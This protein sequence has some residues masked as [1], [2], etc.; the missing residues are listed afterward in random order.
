EDP[1]EMG[2][3]ESLLTSLKTEADALVRHRSL[4]ANEIR[5]E[6]LEETAI[7]QMQTDGIL[8]TIRRRVV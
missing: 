1:N 2:S 5:P 4:S 8:S 6:L 3:V 7:L